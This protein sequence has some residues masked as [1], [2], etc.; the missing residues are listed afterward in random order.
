MAKGGTMNNVEIENVEKFERY[1]S[2]RIEENKVYFVGVEF[3][4]KNGSRLPLIYRDEDGYL[5]VKEIATTFWSSIG[6]T[7]FAPT[8]YKLL[9][10]VPIKTHIENSITVLCLAEGKFGKNWKRGIEILKEEIRKHKNN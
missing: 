10:M 9:K 5:I 8:R 4:Y 6:C 2:I 7:A 1:Y 3:G